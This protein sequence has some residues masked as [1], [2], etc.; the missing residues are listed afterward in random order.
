[1]FCSF[2]DMG[3]YLQ[4]IVLPWSVAICPTRY[5]T[6]GT[7]RKEYGQSGY[8]SVHSTLPFQDTRICIT[9]HVRHSTRTFLHSRLLKDYVQTIKRK[10]REL[11]YIQHAQIVAALPHYIRRLM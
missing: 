4:N 10:N 7:I 5:S 2:K 3:S 11:T 8:C 6:S 9:W 1:M